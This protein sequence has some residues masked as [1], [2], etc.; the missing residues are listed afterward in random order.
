MTKT[1]IIVAAGKG[2][3]MKSD[4]PKQFMLLNDYPILM[5]TIEKFIAYNNQINIIVVL[6]KKYFDT[7]NKHC[8]NYNF[9]TAHSIVA[10]GKTRY[11]SVK[12]ALDIAPDHGLI[13]IHDGVRPLINTATI[14]KCFDTA[15][16]KGNAIPVNQI[17]NSVR[18]AVNNEYK[19]TNRDQLKLVQT[20][21]IFNATLIKKA[22]D[23]SYN[24]SITDDG[25]LVEMM[26]HKIYMVEGNPENIKITTRMDLIIATNIIKENSPK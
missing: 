16:K 23:Q 24:T 26:G 8:K 14:K 25:R 18:I 13:A 11:H 21:Q 10:G 2:I 6:D 5:H 17:H 22:Y 12:N 20:P 7:W 3:R 19:Y 4:I 1:V 9:S 15:E